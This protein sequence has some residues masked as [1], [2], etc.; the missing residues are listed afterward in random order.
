[1][2]RSPKLSKFIAAS[3]LTILLAISAVAFSSQ[4]SN[5]GERILVF[6]AASLQEA[7][8]EIGDDFEKKTGHNVVISTA[9]SS[10]IARQVAAG[11]PAQLVI[12]A[13][14]EWMNWLEDRKAI[15]PASRKII[16]GNTL[17]LAVRNEVEN[18]ADP[19]KLL[20]QSRFAMAE[21]ASVPAGRYARQALIS[22]E[23]WQLAKSNA[24]FTENVR[25]A[26]AMVAR[27]DVGAA[28][29]YGSDVAIE[30][31]VRVL[32]EFKPTDHDA[33]LYHS[34]LTLKA[35]AAAQ[36]LQDY[37]R[38]PEAGKVFEKLGFA[39]VKN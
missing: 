13:D 19:E 28:I 7:L 39:A 33:I 16:A 12:T 4:T 5:A 6:A 27:G 36:S 11:A 34:A 1:M 18:W 9:A 30:P 10:T 2:F 15:D 8:T 31:R 32:V 29:V 35:G 20:I 38:G 22:Q 26:L 14:V 24:I 3:W 23:I 25:V 37:L 17:V 21:S